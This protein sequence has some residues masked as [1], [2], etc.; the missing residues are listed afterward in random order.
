MNCSGCGKDIPFHGDVCPYCQRDKSTD[1]D[2]FTLAMFF[3][4]SLGLVG[5]FIGYMFGGFFGPILSF[6]FFGPILGFFLGGIVGVGIAVFMSEPQSTKSAP[7]EV[8]IKRE[9]SRVIS[10]PGSDVAKRLENL[11]AL[12][13][14]GLISDSEYASKRNSILDHL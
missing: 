11:E 2:N 9:E 4:G 8:R 10:S 7:P 12:K 1:K 5:G 3:G 6:F 14:K 13:T